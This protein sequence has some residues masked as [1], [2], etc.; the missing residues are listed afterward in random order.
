MDNVLI[1]VD[2]LETTKAFFI[3]LASRSKARRQSNSSNSFLILQTRD[4][5]VSLPTTIVIYAG[6]TWWP[7]ASRIQRDRGPTDSVA[8]TYWRSHSSSS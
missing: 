5:D 4:I 8:G 2:D 7:R 1:V 3:E 6:S